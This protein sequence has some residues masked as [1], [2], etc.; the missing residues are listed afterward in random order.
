MAQASFG[1]WSPASAS[2]DFVLLFVV[3]VAIIGLL[4]VLWGRR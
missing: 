2:Q 4:W 1:R 3:F